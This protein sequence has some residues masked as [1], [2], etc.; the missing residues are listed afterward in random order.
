MLIE[1]IKITNFKQ[2][3]D[4]EVDITTGTDGLILFVGKGGSGKS[5]FVS[6]LIWGLSDDSHVEGNIPNMNV[7]KGT[8]VGDDVVVSTEITICNLEHKVIVCKSMRC[9]R[10]PRNKYSVVEIEQRCY[11]KINGEYVQ[12]DKTVGSIIN[13]NYVC[14]D[15]F[16]AHNKRHDWNGT[17]ICEANKEYEILLTAS[18]ICDDA[19]RRIYRMLP[20]KNI[21]HY[22]TELKACDEKI[23]YLRQ[24]NRE[25]NE[26]IKYYEEMKLELR[27]MLQQHSLSDGQISS[28]TDDEAKILISKLQDAQRKFSVLVDENRDNSKKWKEYDKHRLFLLKELEKY[29]QNKDKVARCERIMMYLKAIESWLVEQIDVEK[30]STFAM[31]NASVRQIMSDIGFPEYSINELLNEIIENKDEIGEWR[32]WLNYFVLMCACRTCNNNEKTESLPL[33]IDCNFSHFGRYEGEKVLHYLSNMKEQVIIL[34][35]SEY[36]LFE[37]VKEK[38]GSRYIVYMDEYGSEAFIEQAL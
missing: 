1:K 38:I 21:E 30:E 15:R 34:T 5:S 25:I 31:V 9:R 33:V 16:I 6:A 3:R 27:E 36:G 26:Q 28:G 14:Y 29:E 11:E 20:S 19:K 2:F 35:N 37:T 7:L 4:V 23:E 32:R 12:L 13:C 17:F 18:R 24:R 22:G 8:K 10:E